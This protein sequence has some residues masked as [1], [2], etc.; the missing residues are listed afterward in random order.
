M[1]N[2]VVLDHFRNPHNA[3]D[4]PGAAATVEVTNPV[5]GDIMRLAVRLEVA[6]LPPL[7]SRRRVASPLSRQVRSSRIFWRGRRPRK[8]A[9]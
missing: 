7:G 8:R 4:L 1:F 3:G 5:C 9:A 2:E 6:G